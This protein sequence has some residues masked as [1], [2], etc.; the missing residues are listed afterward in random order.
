MKIRTIGPL[1]VTLVRASA[2]I[3]VALTTTAA[4][5]SSHRGVQASR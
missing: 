5:S 4:W 2:V 1:A 3:A